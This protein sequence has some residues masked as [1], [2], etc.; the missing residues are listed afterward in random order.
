MRV[1]PFLPPV[2]KTK[3]T[4]LQLGFSFQPVRCGSQLDGGDEGS[5]ANSARI[6][7]QEASRLNERD[8]G[9]TNDLMWIWTRF[10]LCAVSKIGRKCI[11]WSVTVQSRCFSLI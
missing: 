1:Q 7:S 5:G 6:S 2:E 9:I 4:D 3:R 10:I 11:L 8:P